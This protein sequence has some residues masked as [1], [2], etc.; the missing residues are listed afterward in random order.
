ML[1]VRLPSFGMGAAFTSHSIQSSNPWTAR[2]VLVYA[3]QGGAKEGPSSCLATLQAAVESGADALELDVHATRDRQLVVC[4]DESVDRTTN[5]SGVIADMDMEELLVLDNAYWWRP[6]HVVDHTPNRPASE[7]P[8]RGKAP[9]DRGFGVAALDEV[10]EQFP[11]VLLNFDIKQTE[12]EVEPYEELLAAA[13]RRH[14]RGD[15][16]IIGSFAD[17]ALERFSRVAPEFATSCGPAAVADMAMAMVKGDPLPAS[18]TRHVALQV[19]TH[20]GE[21]PLVTPETVAYA[22]HHG[23]AVHVWTIDETAEMAAL[24]H[25][26]VD[27]LISDRPSVARRVVDEAG[28]AWRS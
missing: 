26:G 2:R 22:H 8:H 13:L 25:M 10:L 7:Y 11:R 14:C 28:L 19:P 18:V 9:G 17:R 15:D 23:L 1:G 12:G 21:T 16:V 5:R 24:L 27:G 6:G 3:H 20:F 4:H